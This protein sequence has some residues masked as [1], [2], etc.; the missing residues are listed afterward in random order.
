MQ[1][2]RSELLQGLCPILNVNVVSTRKRAKTID[3]ILTS[4]ENLSEEKVKLQAKNRKRCN[5]NTETQKISLVTKRKKKGIN[6]AESAT[7][8]K[9]NEEE[10]FF[11]ESGDSESDE[12]CCVG[13]GEHYRETKN[14]NDWIQCLYCKKWYNEYCGKYENLCDL[15]GKVFSKK[16]NMFGIISSLKSLCT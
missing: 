15:C 5:K 6:L 2:T 11:E 10:F 16:N 14:T 3:T 12:E 1:E 7:S 9:K 13:C 4:P 8:S